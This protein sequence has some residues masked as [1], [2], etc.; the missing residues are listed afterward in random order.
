[1]LTEDS[2]VLEYEESSMA[3]MSEHTAAEISMNDS[4]I[5]P[6]NLLS[7]S[8]ESLDLMY[9]DVTEQIKTQE[10]LLAAKR[11]ELHSAFDSFEKMSFAQKYVR[12]N[13][14]TRKSISNEIYSSSAVVTGISARIQHLKEKLR[15]LDGVAHVMHLNASLKECH[16]KWQEGQTHSLVGLENEQRSDMI[17]KTECRLSLCQ[18]CFGIMM[19]TL[20]RHLYTNKKD[21]GAYENSSEL[22]RAAA[23]LKHRVIFVAQA[24]DETRIAALPAE[25]GADEVRRI[26][27]LTDSAYASEMFMLAQVDGWTITAD[28]ETK[29]LG[30]YTYFFTKHQK[31]KDRSALLDAERADA[32]VAILSS[33]PNRTE[34]NVVDLLRVD[35]QTLIDQIGV[36]KMDLLR[37]QKG[38]DKDYKNYDRMSVAQKFFRRK[39]VTKGTLGKHIYKRSLEVSM[40]WDEV[41]YWK[42][43]L[44][45]LDLICSACVNVMLPATWKGLRSHGTFLRSNFDVLENVVVS[46]NDTIDPIAEFGY[47]FEQIKEK[48]DCYDLAAKALSEPHSEVIQKSRARSAV[49]DDQAL[50]ILSVNS[51]ELDDGGVD[52]DYHEPTISDV[53]K[54]ALRTTSSEEATTVAKIALIDAQKDLESIPISALYS[55]RYI[56]KCDE[57]NL[58]KAKRDETAINSSIAHV[59]GAYVN[60]AGCL[61]RANDLNHVLLEGARACDEARLHTLSSMEFQEETFQ[62][63]EMRELSYISRIFSLAGVQGWNLSKNEVSE[64][65]SIAEKEVRKRRA[66]SS[67]LLIPSEKAQHEAPI[68]PI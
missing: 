55:Y 17:Y 4:I 27:N 11:E 54:D 68:S 57:L 18:L 20:G 66:L 8:I 59:K 6:K 9:C 43:E 22:Y 48:I 3:S 49:S 51:G 58:L 29:A 63:A 12:R 40:L 53:E 47:S 46:E 38:M 45:R 25:I 65:A 44:D 15:Q 33:K 42:G 28:D 35:R 21:C 31:R 64:F 37:L 19:R 13:S 14:K 10:Q 56:V 16:K 26:N 24:Y 62:L 50:L 36:T 34:I 39:S 7:M 1:M 61:K 32:E 5:I 30:V 2:T 60:E 67:D 41:K 23:A 52:I